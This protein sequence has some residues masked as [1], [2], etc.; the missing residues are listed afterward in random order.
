VYIVKNGE[1]QVSKKL[2][3]KAR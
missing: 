2:I 1:F 3:M